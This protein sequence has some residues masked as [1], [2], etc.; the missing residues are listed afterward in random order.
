M[1]QKSLKKRAQARRQERGFTLVEMSIVL[2]IIGLIVGGVLV[3]QDLVKA[4]QIRA[5]VSQ[6][7]QYDAAINTFRGKYDC[8]PG[9][10]A[11]ATTFLGCL[12]GTLGGAGL[13]CNGNGNGRLDDLAN[14]AT[15][16]TNTLAG[17]FNGE[18][19]AFWYHLSLAN[20]VAGQ[21]IIT[22]G[23]AV[24]GAAVDTQYPATKLKKGGIIAM[25]EGATG[26]WMVGVSP[27]LSGYT[28]AA[29]NFITGTGANNLTATEAYGID[30][31]LDDGMVNTGMAYH[32]RANDANALTAIGVQAVVL[33]GAAGATCWAATPGAATTPVDYQLSNQNNACTLRIRMQGS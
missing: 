10:C 11:K 9:D 14:I 8:L 33:T 20:M 30:N 27:A 23:A 19:Q 28:A 13:Q 6:V 29:A 4:A 3:G 24:T 31:K 7:Q 1:V 12:T 16:G 2:V 25:S 5:V 18:L 17:A 22:T 15:P 21:Y 26:I 32:V